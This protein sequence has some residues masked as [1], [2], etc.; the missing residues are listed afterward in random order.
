[1]KLRVAK[2][3]CRNSCKRNYPAET[4][5]RAFKKYIPYL[6]KHCAKINKKLRAQ[7]S[8]VIYVPYVMAEMVPLVGNYT[9]NRYNSINVN[10]LLYII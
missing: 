3:V 2:K 4:R 10:S 5:N 9:K 7:G 1:M 8:S 6:R